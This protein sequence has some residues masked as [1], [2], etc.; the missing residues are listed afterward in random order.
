MTWIISEHS[1]V[2][3]HFDLHGGLADVISD[4]SE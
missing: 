2:H 4:G 3:A 1:L